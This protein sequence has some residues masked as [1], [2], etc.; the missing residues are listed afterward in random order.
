MLRRIG[1]YCLVFSLTGLASA[2]LDA[3]EAS[4]AVQDLAATLVRLQEDAARSTGEPLSASELAAVLPE[5]VEFDD[6]GR[7]RAVR[8]AM[9]SR[10]LLDEVARLARRVAELEAA[11]LPAEKRPRLEPLVR[12]KV[13]RHD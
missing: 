6:Q 5:V 7:P 9:L 4:Q 13:A 11:S 2:R 3:P 12:I 8:Y 1:V 10:I